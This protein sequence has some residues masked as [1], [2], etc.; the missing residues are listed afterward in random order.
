MSA[1]IIST[2]HMGKWYHEMPQTITSRNCTYMMAPTFC[3]CQ[4]QGRVQHL[5][6]FIL[7]SVHVGPSASHP[8]PLQGNSCVYGHGI[9]QHRFGSRALALDLPTF[10]ISDFKGKAKWLFLAR[11]MFCRLQICTWIKASVWGI[12]Q[13]QKNKH[14]PKAS[15][16][17]IVWW[18]LRDLPTVSGGKPASVK[19]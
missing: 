3:S 17:T 11:W 6:F 14:L 15:P 9:G 5:L 4:H 8:R 10:G 7:K 18:V 19:S 13:W 1:L 16:S 12:A 2:F